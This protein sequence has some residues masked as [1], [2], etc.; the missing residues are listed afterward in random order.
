MEPSNS[1]RLAHVVP[2]VYVDTVHMRQ[3]GSRAVLHAETVH[4][5]EGRQQVQVL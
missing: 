1:I 3:L 2:L 4:L 5:W